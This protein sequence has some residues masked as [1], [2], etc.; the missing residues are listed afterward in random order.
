MNTEVRLLGALEV[1]HDGTEIRAG[2]PKQR[3]LLA[4]L[5]LSV[6]RIVSV[7]RLLDG[8]WGDDAPEGGAASLQVH[9]SNLRKALGPALG[10]VV[11]T[12]SPGYVLELP[13]NSVD[14]IRFER[15][16]ERSRDLRRAGDLIGA[17]GMLDEALG[18]WR[19][20]PLDD[21]RGAPFAHSAEVRLTEMRQSAVEERIDL[22]LACGEHQSVVAVLESAVTEYP[23]RERLWSQLMVALYRSGRQADA[24]GAYRRAREH[25]LEELGIEPG[26]ELRA[27]ELAVLEQS[28]SLDLTTTTLSP[29]SATAATSAA[30]STVASTATAA[31]SSGSELAEP[32][33]T[34]KAPPR[35]RAWITLDDGTE[36]PLEGPI[37]LG[38][39][40]D[41][42]IHLA[43][44]SASRRHAELRPA[45]GGWLLIDLDSTNGTSINGD[46]AVHRLL[47]DGD[48]I[49]IGFHRFTYRSTSH[50]S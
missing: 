36:H 22:L 42:E 44:P 21:L 10:G 26:A 28:P 1:V 18:L 11:V 35:G 39:H 13:P 50:G 29:N 25:L 20:T 34:V 8:L 33:I 16:I 19:G 45:V 7:D 14:A 41:C 31:T 23:L 30:A 32:N 48:V 43:D 15:L 40:P 38:R 24:L 6:G 47:I 37:S 49:G 3:G 12:R 4:L 46:P 2:G 17:R 27:L 9:V 5:A